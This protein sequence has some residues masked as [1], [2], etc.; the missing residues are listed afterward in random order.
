MEDG[1][2]QGRPGRQ[3]LPAHYC[4]Y[5]PRKRAAADKEQHLAEV[6]GEGSLAQTRRQHSTTIRPLMTWESF[7]YD[8]QSPCFDVVPVRVVSIRVSCCDGPL[9]VDMTMTFIF[10][11]GH[12]GCGCSF[13]DRRRRRGEGSSQAV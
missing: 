4:S 2:E 1:T 6:K 3:R 11:L 10:V 7:T 12:I 5:T 9:S 13:E 8:D